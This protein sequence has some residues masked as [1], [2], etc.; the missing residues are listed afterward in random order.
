MV[1]ASGIEA[2][3]APG[4]TAPAVHV[5]IDTKDVLACS[6]KHRPFISLAFWPY[7]RLVNLTCIVAADAS[8]ELLAAEVL[9]GDDV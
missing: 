1:L 4:T 7:T 5:L 9:D 3:S 2:L 8:V 6:T